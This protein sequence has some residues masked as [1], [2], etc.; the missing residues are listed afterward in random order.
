MATEQE[1]TSADERRQLLTPPPTPTDSAPFSVFTP[2]QKR[3]ILF[4][5]G[6]ASFFSPLSSFIFY[7][8]IVPI[9]SDLGVTV[10]LVNLAITTYMIVSGIVPAI[11]GSAADKIGR[12]PVY[13]LA[14]SIYFVANIGLATQNSYPALLVLRMVQSAGSSGTISLGYGIISDIATPSERGSYVGIFVLGPN[15]APPLGPVIGGVIAAKLGWRW[16]FWFLVIFGGVCLL[17]I[18]LAL[19]ET[20]RTI[21]GNGSIPATGVNQTLSSLFLSKTRKEGNSSAEGTTPKARLASFPNPLASFKLLLQQDLLVLLL[22][23]GI[24]YAACACVQTSLSSLFV[25]VYGYKELQ[26]GLIYI[27][28]GKFLDFEYTRIA[29]AHGYDPDEA[30]KKLMDGFPIELA[31]LRSAFYVVVLTAVATTGYG[32]AVQKQVHVAIPLA[33]Q[34]VIGFT[35]SAA[36]VAFGTLIT[37]LNPGRSSTAA[38]SSNIVRASLAAAGTAALQPIIDAV[39]AGWCFTI[40]GFIF[41][42]C[43]PLI[44]YQIKIGPKWRKLRGSK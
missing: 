34:A 41:A 44:I 7:P 15:V 42:T 8:A 1:I 39:G 43:G 38:A 29:R 25:Q 16:I 26:A 5:A 9:A 32:W 20:S 23:N 10:G 4:L 21:V 35:A 27:P 3:W 28:F 13:I 12:R 37:D 2:P 22:C 14:L 18:L 11:L 40:F 17:T 30:R 24:F 36:F 6:F 31:R 33:I 19:P